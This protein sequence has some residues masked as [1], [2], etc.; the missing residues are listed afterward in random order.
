[1]NALKKD[2][3]GLSNLKELEEIR[4]KYLGKQGLLAKEFQNFAKLSAEEKK[5]LGEQLNQVKQAITAL[6]DDRF[7]FL[8][9]RELEQALKAEAI[10]VTLPGREKN[11][12]S[13]HPISYVIEEIVE[14][15]ANMGF[16]IADGPEVDS[17]YYNF[18]ALNFPPNHPAKES[19]DT[20]YVE[21]S[22][23]KG[24]M[25][26]RTHTS[27]VQIREMEK[28]KPPF[29]FAS[30]GKVY[31]CDYDATHTPMFQQIECLYIDKGV[32]MK[33]LKGCMYDF[34]KA[35]F[36]GKNVKIRFRPSFFPFVEPGGELDI[37]LDDSGKWLEILGCGMVH[38]NVLR[39]VNIDPEI[40]QGFA[41]GMGVERCAMLKYKINDCRAFYEGDIR[42]IKNNGFK[43]FNVPRLI[44]KVLV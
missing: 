42:Q 30:L 35:F 19:H 38:P 14:I 31:R 3:A 44:D 22:D 25:L 8:E 7:N 26:L 29:K 39:N 10:D 34:A 18:T 33:H 9:A 21:A 11:F 37:M 32:N 1:M 13:I 16:K 5:S 17:E 24:R 6:I 12:G 2:I 15:F 23:P 41:F 36:A 20:F 27:T 43:F 40:Y 28:A 4:V